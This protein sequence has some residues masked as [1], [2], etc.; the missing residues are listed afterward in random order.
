MFILNKHGT[1]YKR[2]KS[3]MSEIPLDNIEDTQ[4]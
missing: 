2:N 4:V 1:K 3:Q